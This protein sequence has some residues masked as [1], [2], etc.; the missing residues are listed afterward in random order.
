MPL[1]GQFLPRFGLTAEP[2]NSDKIE[3][4][5]NNQHVA[6]KLKIHTE[7]LKSQLKWTPGRED[8]QKTWMITR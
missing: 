2:I 6:N 5:N 8:Y 1:M 3:S 7:I 4:L